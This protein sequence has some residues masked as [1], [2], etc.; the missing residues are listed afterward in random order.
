[1]R[2]VRPFVVC[3]AAAVLALGA[4]S[5]SSSSDD[6]TP[7]PSTV[8]DTPSPSSSPTG[9]ATPGADAPVVVALGDS[10]AAGF[11][12]GQ[13][14]VP[15]TSYPARFTEIASARGSGLSMVNLACSGE[16]ARTMI[17]GGDCTYA[18][19]NQLAEAVAT[20]TE[21]G[22]S[23]AAVTIDIGGND[24]LRCLSASGPDAGCGTAAVADLS[25]RLG[26]ILGQLRVAAPQT[27]IALVSYYDPF[28]VLP[29]LTADNKAIIADLWTQLNAA[30]ASQAQLHNVTLVDLSGI[31]PL[32]EATSTAS[33][34]AD[35]PVCSLTWMCTRGDF[36]LNDAGA[37]AVGQQVA[38]ALP[39]VR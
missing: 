23:V 20:L 1:M 9:S 10:L 14:V 33:P 22:E 13:G 28:S 24:M 37:L 8:S 39:D 6:A 5:S 16:T 21:R 29:M 38:T 36:H 30:L 34:S 7:T 18:A 19:G 15:A 3:V 35:N 27:P 26:T 4:C 31:F 25:E 17:E 11:Q 2:R 12:P 32:G